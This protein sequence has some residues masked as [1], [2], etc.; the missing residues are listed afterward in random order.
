MDALCWE[1]V[2]PLPPGGGEPGVNGERTRGGD[3]VDAGGIDAT[4]TPAAPADEGEE[5]EDGDME[6]EEEEGY[7]W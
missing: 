5:L 2:K 4:T 1:A 7:A 3:D 6:D